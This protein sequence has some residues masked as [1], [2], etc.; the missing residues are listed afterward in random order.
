M[1]TPKPAETRLA[2]LDAYRGLIMLSLLSGGFG[3]GTYANKNP[4]AGLGWLAQQLDH[5]WWVGCVYW[6]LIQPAFMFMVGAAAAYSINKR[7]ERGDSLWWVYG[8]SAIRAVVLVLLGI[9]LASQGAETTDYIFTNVLAQI[10]LG[11]FFLVLLVGQGWKIQWIAIA[12]I[13]VITWI[14]F[15]VYPSP[16][17]D[18][19][20][21]ALFVKQRDIDA[22][23]VREGFFSHWNKGTNIIGEFD[24]WFL[25]KFPRPKVYPANPG[26]Y[27]T[28]NFIPSL[29]TM[30]LGLWAGELLRS[31]KPTGQ[32]IGLMLGVGAGC[33]FAGW[34]LGET[35]CP[36]VKRIWTPS[37]M[38][39]SGGW[40]LWGLLIFYMVVDL[41]HGKILAF[42]LIVLGMNSMLVYMISQMAKP[43]ILRTAK[44][45]LPTDWFT[46]QYQ[47]II[48]A[49]IVTVIV[50]L[51]CLWLYRQKIF[52]RI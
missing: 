3:I 7:R 38:L 45:H 40:V 6:D 37:F 35:I 29:A 12:S 17:P 32:K 19:D 1:E 50:W 8:H 31:A 28:L 51:F 5:V 23:A 14:A 10:G 18:T 33:L 30:I 44:T 22:G 4:E 21:A 49:T 52:L 15:V 47:P 9:F 11:Y 25:N 13:L 2:S 43:W 24:K 16:P 34:G 48:E 27:G 46:G 20:Y 39:L 42:P 26:G 41:A 36:I